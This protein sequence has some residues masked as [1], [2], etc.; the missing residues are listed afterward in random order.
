M[1]SHAQFAVTA[2]LTVC[3]YYSIAW[4]LFGRDPKLGTLVP[5]Y[6]PPRNLSPAMLRYLWKKNFDERVVWAG[7]LSLVAKGVATLHSENGVTKL[8]GSSAGAQTDLPNEER[9]LQSELVRGHLRKG[10]TISMLD[11]S[12]MLALTDMA[13][14]LR[15]DA[16]GRWFTEN[17]G[18]VIAGTL[19]SA[20][21]LCVVAGPES[22]EQW[23]VLALG[24]AVTA[25]GV[26]YLFFLTLRA[27][28]LLRAVR[29][30]WDRA[31]LQRAAMVFAMLLPCVAAITLGAVVLGVTFGWPFLIG[32]LFLAVLNVLLLQW[33]KAPT[34]EGTQVL[35]ELEGFRAF[36]K[37]VERLPMQRANPP[38]EHAGLYEKYLPYAMALEV[39]QRWG[40]RFVAM[41]STVHE[42]AGL[43]QAES[44]Y[45]GMWE[46]KPLEIVYKPEPPKGRAF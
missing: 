13:S 28:D 20:I 24:L 44:F 23:G 43:P 39:E 12:T 21:A 40:D 37:S 41:A 32:A 19:L 3:V 18:L 29:G 9:V 42:N 7:I 14:S 16:V 15:R 5:R 25:P 33:M 11:S 30:N 2:V 27:R 6:D 4:Y 34:P 26:F 38:G 22:K 46:G 17:R 10:A 31:V 45:L 1:I 36:L 8:Q 35:A